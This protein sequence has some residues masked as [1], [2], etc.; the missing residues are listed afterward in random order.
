MH[1]MECFPDGTLIDPWFFD[2]A[3][4]DPKALGEIY[5]IT[6]FGARDDGKIHTAEIQEAI[7]LA[8]SRGG[9]VVAVPQGRFVSG[10][11][12]LRQGVHL[13]V[14]EGGVLMGSDDISDYPLMPTRIEGQSCS[15]FAALLN[16]E[17]IRGL[18]ILGPGTIDGNGQRAWKSFW[19]RRKW[20]PACTN[21]DEQRARLIFLSDCEDVTVAGICLRNA[22]FWTNHLYRCRRVKYLSC[23]IFSPRSP[24]PAPSTDALDIDVCSDVLVKDCLME[25]NDD[26]VALKGGK[27]PWADE[28]PEN[29]S[30]ERILIEDCVYGF[31]H[32]CLTCGSESVHNRNILM[33]RV[34]VKDGYNLLWFKLRPDTPQR[35]EYISAEDIRGSIET[36][37]NVHPWTQFFD[38][39][40]RT[41]MPLSSVSRISIRRSECDCSTAFHVTPDPGRYILRG[42]EL[43]DLQITAD[44]R[45][46]DMGTLPESRVKNVDIMVRK[47][48]KKA[49]THSD[50]V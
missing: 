31:C 22:Q 8:A 9:G 16:A 39:Q 3:V 24:V 40:G 18:K 19:L 1:H 42:F 23:S 34:E 2:A 10:A 4:P 14:Q 15:Y 13:W 27:G 49:V 26:A 29:G 25:V 21:K 50:A 46:L 7:D 45:G 41:D 28:A 17:G 11:L 12:F 5:P 33:R 44:E 30:N 48:A 37:V 35:Y 47:G 20:N 32:G 36:F 43:E 38:L 6:D